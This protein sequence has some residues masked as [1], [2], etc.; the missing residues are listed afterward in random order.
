MAQYPSI[1]TTYAGLNMIAESQTG[2]KLIFTKLKAGDGSLSDGESIQSLT[3]LKSPKLDIPIQGFVNQGNG[4]IRLRFVVSNENAESGFHM[5]EVAIYAKLEE[6]GEEQLYAYVNG[7]NF[8]DWIPDKNIPMEAQIFDIFV[9]IGNASS[10]IV[11]IDKSIVYATALD[12]TEHNTSEIAH[13][14]I[15]KKIGTDITNHNTNKDAHQNGI[16]GNAATAT[17]LETPRKINGISFDGTTDI[18][19]T[20]DTKQPYYSGTI[21]IAGDANKFY[22]VAFWCSNGNDGRHFQ[23]N[24]RRPKHMDAQDTGFLDFEMGGCGS[25]WGSTY[26]NIYTRY[27]SVVDFVADAKPAA[28]STIM[29]VWLKGGGTTYY[30]GSTHPIFSSDIAT[31]DSIVIQNDTL[32]PKTECTLPRGLAE[33]G[34]LYSPR[35]FAPSGFGLG[36]ASISITES[37]S[38]ETFLKRSGTQS[39]FYRSS[40]ITDLPTP[41]DSGYFLYVTKS[42]DPNYAGVYALKASIDARAYYGCCINGTWRG[43]GRIATTESPAFTGTPTA[44]TPESTDNSTKIATTAFVQT[45]SKANGGIVAQSLGETGWVKYANGL[46]EQWGYAT[47]GAGSTATITLPILLTSTIYNIQVSPNNT[48]VDSRGD[49]QDWVGASPASLNA[50]VIRNGFEHNISSSKIWWKVMGV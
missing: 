44:P 4:Q 33:N 46:I 26:P 45:V 28:R 27:Y 50:I 34:I 11:N 21:K 6:S 25:S 16:K 12:L 8:V 13:E 35:A 19:I 3:A 43:W 23:V 2:K 10:V 31:T 20:D 24:I 49:K 14:D 15:R 42:S 32:A 47:V 1:T 9:I 39:G 5:K 22:P 36:D 37:I 30:W 18:T 7:G 17:K 41:I 29:H 48:T 40:T 38:M